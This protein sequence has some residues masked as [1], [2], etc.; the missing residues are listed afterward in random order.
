MHTTCAHRLQLSV[1]VG[2]RLT[3]VNAAQLPDDRVR[4]EWSLQSR[5]RRSKATFNQVTLSVNVNI[6][7]RINLTDVDPILTDK[8]RVLVAFY[9]QYVSSGA[10]HS[11]RPFKNS[12]PDHVTRSHASRCPLSPRFPQ[13]NSSKSRSQQSAT[14]CSLMYSFIMTGYL[15]R[16]G[17]YHLGCRGFGSARLRCL[18][19]GW[20]ATGMTLFQSW[21]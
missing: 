7:S 6:W 11:H 18:R 1:S 4:V 2:N 14:T 10:T 13:R 16:A 15:F 21:A 3:G 9:D 8:M 20:G 12:A 5:T 19:L 17:G